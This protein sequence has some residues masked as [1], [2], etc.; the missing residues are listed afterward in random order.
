MLLSSVPFSLAYLRVL[1]QLGDMLNFL[2][3]KWEFFL[4]HPRLES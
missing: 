4:G 1:A 2:F 3:A